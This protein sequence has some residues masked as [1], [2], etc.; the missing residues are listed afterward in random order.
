M[1]SILQA[2]W[3]QVSK[4]VEAWIIWLF[5]ISL[6]SNNLVFAQSQHVI[7]EEQIAYGKKKIKELKQGALL[8]RLTNPKSRAADKETAKDNLDIIKAFNKKFDFCPVYFFY[9]EDS[10]YV[11]NRQ[12]SNVRFINSSGAIDAK[13]KFNK[14]YFLTAEFQGV[15]VDRLK[16]NLADTSLIKSYSYQMKYYSLVVKTEKFEPM[17]MPFPFFIRNP[18]NLSNNRR[19]EKTIAKLSNKFHRYHFIAVSKDEAG[20]NVK[21]VDKA[22]IMG[23]F[24][25]ILVEPTFVSKQAG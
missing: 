21:S 6:A 8:V 13:I 24:P 12:F 7:T 25:F 18:K 16:K 17:Q 5:F 2:N 23:W 19:F 15:D 20:K 1:K 22:P 14:K 11:I 4:P 3:R 10:K 9:A